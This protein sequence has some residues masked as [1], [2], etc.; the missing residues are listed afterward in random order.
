MRLTGS[1]RRGSFVSWRIRSLPC[2]R[3]ECRWCRVWDMRMGINLS[4]DEC[5]IAV[6][7]AKEENM[8]T[9]EVV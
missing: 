2:P 4:E 9:Q 8:G 5:L 7:I 3:G 6:L 1:L